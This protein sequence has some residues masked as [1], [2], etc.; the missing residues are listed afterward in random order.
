MGQQS[1]KKEKKRKSTSTYEK[2]SFLLLPLSADC[3]TVLKRR[4]KRKSSTHTSAI[5]TLISSFATQVCILVGRAGGLCETQLNGATGFEGRV[6]NA[7]VLGL[8]ES[9]CV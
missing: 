2:R 7:V 8:K 3:S 1:G 4:T 6:M 9:L 5:G